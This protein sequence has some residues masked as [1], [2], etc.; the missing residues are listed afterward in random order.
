[1]NKKTKWRRE[2]S[3]K[4]YEYKSLM[5]EAGLNERQRRVFKR[6][7][8]SFDKDELI[9]MLKMMVGKVYSLADT[10][11]LVSEEYHKKLD[12]YFNEKREETP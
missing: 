1:M 8:L 11:K 12:E 9:A 10:E 4:K 3:P 5:K 6:A 7:E 2:S